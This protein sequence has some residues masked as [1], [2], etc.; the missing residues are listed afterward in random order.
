MRRDPLAVCD[1]R[2][3]DM[4]TEACQVDFRATSPFGEGEYLQ[5]GYLV[6]KPSEDTRQKWYYM[7]EQKPNEVLVLKLAD[8]GNENDPSISD[9]VA[10]VAAALDGSDNIEE[11]RQSIE[12]RVM[13]FW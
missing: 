12:V 11:P 10:H 2:T 7:S 5:S 8:T 6:P 13:A 9:G 1:Y 3:I 4:E